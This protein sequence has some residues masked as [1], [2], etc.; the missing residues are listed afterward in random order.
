M[1]HQGALHFRRSD[2]MARNI[3]H[4]IDPSHQPEITVL[5]SLGSIP[6]EVITRENRKIGVFE[7]LPLRVVPETSQHPRPGI[8]KDGGASFLYFAFTPIFPDD[9]RDHTWKGGSGGS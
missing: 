7:S 3:D 5:I 8:G 1:R 6:R 4:I 2:A 9:L